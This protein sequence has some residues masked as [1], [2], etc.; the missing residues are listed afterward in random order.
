MWN[1]KNFIVV[2]MLTF[3][4]IASN[5]LGITGNNEPKAAELVQAVRA[6]ENWIHDVESMYIRI[7]T[8]LTRTPEVIAAKTTELKQQYPDLVPDSSQFPELKPISTGI[9]EFAIDKTKVRSLS[10]EHDSRRQVKIWDGKQLMSHDVSFL[11]GQEQYSLAR[12]PQGC[13]QDMLAYETS[14][15]RAQPHSFWWD[16]RDVDEL[17][18]YYG[19]AEDSS[20]A[21]R[22][23]YRGTD[24][25][26]LDVPPRGIPGLVVV[27]TYPGC[28]TCS[29]RR[30]YGLAG[31]A[32][33]LAGQSF[34]WYV[35][36][37]DHKLYGL[38]WL[39]NKKPRIEYW[40]SDYKEI[41][42]G[43][44]L[45]MTQGCEVYRK[46]NSG[47]PRVETHSDL[48][49]VNARINESVPD[50]LFRMEIKEG[51][52]VTDSRS[53]RTIMYT[54]KPEPPDLIGKALPESVDTS[55]SFVPEQAKNGRMLICFWDMQQR[56]SRHCLKSLAEKAGNFADK[57]ISVLCVHASEV[58]RETLNEWMKD[59]NVP[60]ASKTI[61]HDLEKTRVVWGVKSLPWL[62]LTDQKHI[63]EANGFSLAELDEKI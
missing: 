32:V 38:V 30:H 7:E 54:H 53:G 31:E 1:A 21:G 34:R 23:N 6:S 18:S 63:V 17:M 29:D 52:M 24:C 45:P 4:F 10:E 49:I 22:C 62:I 15:P 11:D 43:C 5:S 3:T 12:T 51:A 56:P 8:K 39:S 16:I 55:A 33:G 28:E 13:F 37:K 40:M 26:I 20:I 2:L 36:A 59:Y 60:F 44:W 41:R 9:L 48:K 35:G 61:T 14:W 47:K 27:Q 50:R 25:Y 42:S 57:G 58:D 19:H 46:D